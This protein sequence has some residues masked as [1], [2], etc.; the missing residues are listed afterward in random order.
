M[1][2]A[3]WESSERCF[4]LDDLAIFSSVAGTWRWRWRSAACCGQQ[5]AA[6]DLAAR[7][8]S[9]SM[10]REMNRSAALNLPGNITAQ[11]AQTATFQLLI[12]SALGCV[13]QYAAQI[14]DTEQYN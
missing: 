6:G 13:V 9:C 7:L 1:E 8:S 11:T 2:D 12:S 14:A 3:T 10:K 4:R 5:R